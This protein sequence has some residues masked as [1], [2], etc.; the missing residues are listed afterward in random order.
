M[1]HVVEGIQPLCS[2]S[3]LVCIILWHFEHDK[4]QTILCFFIKLGRHV[5]HGERKRKRSDSVLWQK[6]LHP[7]NNPK[8]NVTTQKRH[9]KL[10]LHY[11]CGLRTVSWSNSSHPTGVVKPVECEPYWFWR[12]KVKARMGIIDKCG[13]CM[14]AMLCVVWVCL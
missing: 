5:N 6:P 1:Q 2:G 7:Q 11:Y 3:I 13:V 10:W 14:D 9:Q 4:D 12:S 8:I